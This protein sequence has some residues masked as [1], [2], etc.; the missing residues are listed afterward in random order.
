MS[1]KWAGHG[2]VNSALNES[3]CSKHWFLWN[4]TGGLPPTQRIL[5]LSVCVNIWIGGIIHTS[6]YVYVSVCVF[7]GREE[8]CSRGCAENESSQLS[9]WGERICMRPLCRV[10]VYVCVN[11]HF[12]CKC[13]SLC[14]DMSH[15]MTILKKVVFLAVNVYRHN[16]RLSWAV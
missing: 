16:I 10:C 8:H 12:G 9:I 11:P 13:I 4:T 14:L 7:A 6:V 1:E 15:Q 5:S 2:S 3:T